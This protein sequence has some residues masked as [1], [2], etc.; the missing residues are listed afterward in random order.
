[1]ESVVSDRASKRGAVALIKDFSIA[2]YDFD[3][4]C[5]AQ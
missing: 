4:L 5:N 1:M 3:K 2:A